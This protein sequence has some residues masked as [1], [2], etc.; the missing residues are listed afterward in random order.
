MHILIKLVHPPLVP[1]CCPYS[2]V[3]SPPWRSWCIVVTK[4]I[5]TYARV[6]NALFSWIN[7]GQ[8]FNCN[9]ATSV[10]NSSNWN[11]LMRL[12]RLMWMM[13][14]VRMGVV[15]WLEETLIK[16]ARFFLPGS[17]TCLPNPPGSGERC[18]FEFSGQFSPAFSH[19]WAQIQIKYNLLAS[20]SS[21]PPD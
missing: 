12:M 14:M 7:L 1:C 6:T 21:G 20:L 5:I 11:G 19:F 17:P 2:W 8:C 3:C 16:L 13:R 4:G 18:P 10:W 9:L 15:G